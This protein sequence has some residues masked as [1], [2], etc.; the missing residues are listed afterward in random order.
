MDL[1][2]YAVFKVARNFDVEAV[3][4]KYKR[5]CMKIHPDRNPGKDTT[6]LFQAISQC[7]QRLLED[8]VARLPDKTHSQL[9][10]AYAHPQDTSDCKR[11]T[12]S[13]DVDKFN[14]VFSSHRLHDANDV[15][16]SDWMKHTTG[17]EGEKAKDEEKKRAAVQLYRPQYSHTMDPQQAF[18]LGTV[19]INDFSR[20]VCMD[21]LGRRTRGL[22]YTDY[23]L[24]HT[25]TQLADPLQCVD[26]HRSIHELEAER[27][28]VNYQM[29]DED[30]VKERR[31]RK[32]EISR[33]KAKIIQQQMRD[34]QSFEHYEKV[35]R[36]MIAGSR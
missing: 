5:F 11:N 27:A 31:E 36:M 28:K 13:F 10:E 15:G 24:A 29:S 22:S 26:Q 14:T 8:Y 9:K 33:E 32:K 2:P 16:Y 4:A 23:R 12:E 6:K 18:E 20:P 21:S 3:K 1:D 25:T 35:N 30:L 7:Y 19:S 17:R 34:Q